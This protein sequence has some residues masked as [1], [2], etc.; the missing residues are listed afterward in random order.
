VVVAS[1]NRGGP[2]QAGYAVNALPTSVTLKLEQDEAALLTFAESVG[3]VKLLLR[4]QNIL[5]ENLNPE[6]TSIE[7][8]YQD[9]QQYKTI[10]SKRLRSIEVTY[11][12]DK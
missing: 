6:K 9:I 4:H 3:E 1:V 8:G 11:G 2:G 7:I 10:S 5:P 12:R